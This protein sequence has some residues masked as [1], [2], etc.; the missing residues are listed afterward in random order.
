MEESSMKWESLNLHLENLL[1]GLVTSL[2]LL[3]LLPE[4]AID[5]LLSC[6]VKD[7]LKSEFVSAGV[8]VGVS[9]LLGILTIAISRIFLDRPSEWYPR[10]LILRL[11]SRGDLKGKSISEVNDKYRELISSVLRGTN[12]AIK[13]EV[14]KRRERGRLIRTALVPVVLSVLQI[15]TTYNGIVRVGWAIIAAVVLLLLYAY[16]EAT[17]Y[18]ECLLA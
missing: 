11:L 9:Y 6:K 18:E 13:T 2:L 7:A 4:N 8:F 3:S 17:V 16:N 14:V 15:T 1:P 12:E 5:S 10:P